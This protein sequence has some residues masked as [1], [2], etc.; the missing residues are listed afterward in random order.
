MFIKKIILAALLFF[1]YAASAQNPNQERIP[2]PN[3][4]QAENIPELAGD[5]IRG[6]LGVTG[7]VALFM[8]VWGGIVWMTSGGNSNR[9]EQ[10][11][12]TIVWSILGILIIFM[13]YIILNFVFDLIGGAA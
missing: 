5:M 2:L 7:A 9:V 6:L 8:L 13:S 10:G 12:N 11:K 4:L 3:P 1:P